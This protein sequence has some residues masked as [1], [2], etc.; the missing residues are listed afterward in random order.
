[1]TDTDTTE[2][3]DIVQYVMKS[4]PFNISVTLYDVRH[5]IYT[6]L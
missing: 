2:T 4:Q 1:M 3:L 6:V 5:S